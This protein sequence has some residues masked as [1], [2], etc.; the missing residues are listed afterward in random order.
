M[1]TKY[2]CAHCDKEFVPEDAVA[3]P[4]CPQCMRRG[5]VE[6]VKEV[7]PEG[8][9][10]RS[11]LLIVALVIVAAGLGYGVY[12]ATTVTLEETPPLR[13]LEAR[14]LS[15]YLER[16]QIRVGAYEPMMVL[17]N[18]VE[19]WP[20]GAA[21]IA[22]RMHGESSP[23]S[24]E[25]PL[26]REVLTADQTLAIM[27]AHEERMALYPLELATAMAALLRDR[28]TKAMV[29]EVWEFEGARAPADPSGML[30]YF[31]TAVYD[32]SASGEPA[33]YFDPWGGRGEVKVSSV[34]VLRD[35]EVLAAA[36]G[37][38]AMRIIARSG[39]GPKALPMVDTALLLDPASPSLRTVN[40]TILVESGGIAQA[41][42]EFEAALQ[43]RPDGPRQLKLMQLHLAQAGMLEMNGQQA[44]AEAQF[45][46]ASR[47]VAEV[48]EKW[49]R[50]GRAHVMLATI[51]LGLDEPERARVELEAAEGLNPDAPMLWAVWA[52]YHLAQSDPIAAATKMKRAVALDPDNWQLRL[53][54][55]RT[56]QGAGDDEAAA[57]NVGAAM[58]LV[59]PS[60]RADIRQFV[61][62]MMGP[63]ALGGA[64]APANEE[65]ADADQ[66]L[67]EPALMLGDPSNLRLRDPGQGLKLDLEE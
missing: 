25:L 24:L 27:D 45:S 55:A 18:E 40:G 33:A 61:E 51:H 26:S 34:R 22:A 32:G 43:L 60:K 1:S 28:G 31:V 9:A 8:D 46:K 29:A 14:E 67:P 64:P 30:G 66:D 16:D 6:L 5:G 13:P 35:T 56:F 63:E 49:P 50:Y 7:A 39:D 57:E 47:T 37:T 59:P 58:Q 41:I 65:G 2:F 42:S 52:Q 23:W 15:A 17:P 38:E 11:W 62:R 19:G 3:K 12:R 21:E 53:Q 4:R 20:E 36:L 48:I 54:A 10:S 44:E